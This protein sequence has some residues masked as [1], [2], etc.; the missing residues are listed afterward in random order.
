MSSNLALTG[1]TD[2]NDHDKPYTF[3]NVTVMESEQQLLLAL[4]VVII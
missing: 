3:V 2:D 1:S 4:G